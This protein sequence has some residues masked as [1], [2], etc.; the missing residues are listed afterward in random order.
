MTTKK[1]S[2]QDNFLVSLSAPARRALENR[3]IKTMAGLSEFTEKEIRSLHGIGKSA[4][5]ILKMELA[6]NGLAFKEGTG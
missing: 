2:P 3:G 6:K 5:P 1:N 4:I